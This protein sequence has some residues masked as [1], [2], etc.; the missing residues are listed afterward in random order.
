M[1]RQKLN[2]DNNKRKLERPKGQ[3]TQ[4]TKYK[5]MT[6]KPTPKKSKLSPIHY[7]PSL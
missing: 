6:Q 5:S 3:K 4:R 1:G 2:Y 7:F